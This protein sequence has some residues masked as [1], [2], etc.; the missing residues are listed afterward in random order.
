MTAKSAFLNN[1]EPAIPHRFR[2]N[3]GPIQ[4]K[5]PLN[6]GAIDFTYLVVLTGRSWTGVKGLELRG[7]TAI[8]LSTPPG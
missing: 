5:K 1:R 6:T 3:R 8:V 7:P 4:N 2:A